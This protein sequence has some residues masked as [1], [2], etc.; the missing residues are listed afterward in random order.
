MDPE[1]IELAKEIAEKTESLGDNCYLRRGA[2]KALGANNTFTVTLGG[3]DIPGVPAY[4][5][6]NPSV[7]DAVDVL[8]DGP[9][10]RIIG[11]LGPASAQGMIAYQIIDVDNKAGY[12]KY[13]GVQGA[14]TDTISLSTT[15]QFTG[16]FCTDIPCLPNRLM[17]ARFHFPAAG[18][19]NASNEWYFL[20]NVATNGGA[21]IL[22]QEVRIAPA[23]ANSPSPE[24]EMIFHTKPDAS[25]VSVGWDARVLTGTPTLWRWSGTQG[26]FRSHLTVEDLGPR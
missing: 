9:V 2:V 26:Y 3:A 11:R 10:P 14:L 1:I 22:N 18:P 19:V 25:R 20:G 17:R 5:G 23:G 7:N 6:V 12:G 8:F 13:A 21:W 24:G 16:M 4:A 15:Q